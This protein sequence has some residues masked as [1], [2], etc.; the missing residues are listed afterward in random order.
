MHVPIGSQHSLSRLNQ[1]GGNQRREEDLMQMAAD[2]ATLLTEPHMYRHSA[3]SKLW[4]GLLLVA[5]AA[6]LTTAGVNLAGKQNIVLFLLYGAEALYLMLCGL[7]LLKTTRRRFLITSLEGIIF[8]RGGYTVFSPWENITRI[9]S[10][11][12]GGDTMP[13]NCARHLPICHLQTG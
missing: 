4:L 13:C 9:A 12:T 1:R 3:R 10:P 2:L 7:I 8:T 11:P 5:I 6:F